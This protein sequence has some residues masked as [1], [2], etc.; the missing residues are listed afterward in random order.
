MIDNTSRCPECGKRI[1]T[2]ASI[3]PAC[4][5]KFIPRIV[6]V[7]CKRCGRRIPADA[8]KCPRCGTARSAE[9][10]QPDARASRAPLVVLMGA[11]LVGALLVVCIGWIIFRALTT[12]VLSRMPGLNDPALTPT[13]VILVTYVIAT[14]IPAAPT[15]APSATL[16]RTSRFSPTPTRRGA[17][18]PTPTRRVTPRLGAYAAPQLI[19]P[20]NATIFTGADA[21]ILLEWQPVS[22]SG[23]PENEWYMISL[24]FTGHEGSPVSQ[25][26]WSK[27]TR[28]RVPNDLWSDVSPNART[29]RWNITV[30]RIE[31]SD[32]FASPSHTPASP[33]SATRSFLWN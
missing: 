6:R 14:P 9:R 7:R 33:T 2:G 31:G 19:A 12:N 27:E 17:R 25:T 13:P 10:A 1:P 28:W 15:L 29:F 30:I 4:G 32:P 20:A 3:C 16:T 18:T 26:G 22:A 24:S 23:L 5:Y 21:S 8:A 11:I